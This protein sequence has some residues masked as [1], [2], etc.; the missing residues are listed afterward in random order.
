[1]AYLNI[2]QRH[3]LVPTNPGSPI[4]YKYAERLNKRGEPALVEIGKEDLREIHQADRD[5]VDLKL[6]V[7]RYQQGDILA[8]ERSSNAFFGDI[9]DMPENAIDAAN[10]AL[11]GRQMFD[12]LPLAVKRQYDNNPL[13]WMQAIADGEKVALES[14]G[15]QFKEK[16]AEPA[17][18]A[19]A[20]KGVV[21]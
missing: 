8:L 20:E 16:P 4:A 2:D 13:K 17:K 3:K 15:V 6:I 1:M 10:R 18:P 12:A 21:E 14:V 11:A 9:R 7:A 19:E 5:S